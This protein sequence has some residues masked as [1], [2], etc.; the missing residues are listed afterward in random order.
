MHRPRTAAR[1][2]TAAAVLAGAL[3]LATTPA[4]AHV[5]VSATNAQALAT[6]VT[7]SF[8]AEAESAASGIT[9]LRVV[10]PAGI[11]PGDVTLAQGPKGWKLAPTSDGYAVAGPA[12]PVGQSAQYAITVRQLP[13][14]KELVFKTLE[15]YSDG[16]IN[17]WIDL[18]QPG[19][20]ASKPAPVL[21]LKAAAAGAST[22]PTAQPSS[23]APASPH[24]R[25]PANPSA[26]ASS[27]D[28]SSP[29][30][31]ITLGVAALALITGGIW[32]WR[33]HNSATTD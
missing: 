10:L 4:F 8:H 5:G 11:A 13:D 22:P 20:V 16:H 14:A 3:A 24:T 30:L 25:T 29:T 31:P 15:T 19:V 18:P 2:A 28:S 21:Q 26:A 9:Q 27:G 6:N 17:R 33:R 1:A 32:W 7:V 23:S 12:L